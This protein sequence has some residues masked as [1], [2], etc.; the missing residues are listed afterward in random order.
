MCVAVPMKIKSLKGHMC[1]AEMGGVSREISCLMLPEA[2]VGDYVIVHAGFAIEKLDEE[3]A[4]RTLD[5]FR[6]LGELMDAE[7]LR[8]E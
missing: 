6:Q 5:L 4:L 7:E 1:E 3:E 2:Q 8:D